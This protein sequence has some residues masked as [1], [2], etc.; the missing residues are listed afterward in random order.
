MGNNYL[1][2]QQLQSYT[3]VYMYRYTV[4][5]ICKYVYKS[6]R[7]YKLKSTIFLQVIFGGGRQNLLPNNETDPEYPDS[8]G[9]RT[10]SRNLMQVVLHIHTVSSSNF[11]QE[12]DFV[13]P[14]FSL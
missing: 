11:S 1:L 8:K 12:L 6:C 2:K 3:Y 9:K 13:N 14:L 5:Y 7:V 10:D 4:L